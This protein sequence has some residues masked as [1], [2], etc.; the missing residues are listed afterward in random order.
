MRLLINILKGI[1]G[2]ISIMFVF[3]G[4]VIF[5]AEK[6][7]SCWPVIYIILGSVFFLILSGNIKK[8]YYILVIPGMLIPFIID[9]IV[10][11]DSGKGVILC[12]LILIFGIITSAL[13]RFYYSKKDTRPTD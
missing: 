1:G 5:S 4:V 8:P 10:Q 6:N 9:Y 2:G 12:T 13:V 3:A 11:F 7:R